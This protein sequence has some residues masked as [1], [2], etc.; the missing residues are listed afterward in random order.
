MSSL[1]AG[2]KGAVIAALIAL[3]AAGLALCGIH[4][5]WPGIVRLG[6]AVLVFT[7]LGLFYERWRP[8]ERLADL[9]HSAARLL[10]FFAAMGV[11]SYLVATTGM[12]VA[13]DLLARADRALGFDW[14]G[15][16]AVVQQHPTLHRVLN[17]AYMSALPQIAIITSYLG[18][19]GQPRRNSELFWMLTLS[20]LII[21][22]ISGLLPAFNASVY[23]GLPG[24]HQHMPDFVALRTGRF[25]QL[26]LSRL[27]GLISFPS[28]HTTLAV[29]FPYAARRRPVALLIT[30][31]VNGAMIVAIPTEG[32]HYFVDVLAGAAVAVLAIAATARIEALLE[33]QRSQP[34][35]A[36]AE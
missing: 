8:E 28:F 30:A 35:L 4:L 2:A 20:L 34:A 18:L 9:A 19:T 15:W 1:N 10:V 36:A 16:F 14:P 21:V 11:F 6:G 17:L 31:L 5:A 27:Q 32:S 12:P 33:R 25:G 7:A 26:D 13:D 22:P 3:D 23:Y 24:F 29:L